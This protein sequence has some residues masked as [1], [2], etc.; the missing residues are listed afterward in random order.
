MF[1]FA[2]FSW[3]METEYLWMTFNLT[4]NHPLSLLASQGEEING[5]QYYSVSGILWDQHF[6][7]GK[8]FNSYSIRKQ[9]SF[10]LYMGNLKLQ[11]AKWPLDPRVVGVKINVKASPPAGEIGEVGANLTTD[12]VGHQLARDMLFPLLS[13]VNIGISY[14]GREI[15]PL[16]SLREE[17]FFNPL[18]AIQ[19]VLKN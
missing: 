5:V 2:E 1:T 8:L 7:V 6:S 14:A 12:S 18:R 17:L 11:E 4:M 15:M 13:S 10:Y 19:V 9:S 3:E 16:D